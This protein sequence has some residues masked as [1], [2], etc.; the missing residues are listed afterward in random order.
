MSGEAVKQEALPARTSAPLTPARAVAGHVHPAGPEARAES[1]LALQRMAGNRATTQAIR[2]HLPSPAAVPDSAGA[3]LSDDLRED[4]ERRFDGD[5]TDVRVHSGATAAR[6]ASALSAKA[7]TVG[8]DIVFSEG[9]FAPQT[10]AGRHLLAHELAHVVQQSRGGPPPP[11]SGSS[12]GLEAA[13][14][15]SAARAVQSDGAIGVAGASSIGVARAPEDE[16]KNKSLTGRAFGFLS[17]NAPGL[18]KAAQSAVPIAETVEAS[19]SP[20]SKEQVARALDFIEKKESEGPPDLSKVTWVG[21]PPLEVRQKQAAAQRE[22]DQEAKK[23]N[24][25]G[26]GD[27]APRPG[28]AGAHDLPP[29]DWR[30]PL[31]DPTPFE[32]QLR[33]GNTF[34]HTLPP[35]KPDIDPR[36]ATWIGGRPSEATMRQTQFQ[37][38]GDLPSS[39]KIYVPGDARTETRISANDVM[40]VRDPDTGE[41]TGYRIKSGETIWEVDRNGNTLDTRGLEGALQEPA[42]DP[43]DVTLMF[44]Q[45][46][47]AIA[48]LVKAGGKALAQRVLPTASRFALRSAR[49]ARGGTTALMVGFARG[50]EGTGAIATGASWGG[51]RAASAEVSQAARG[52]VKESLEEAAAKGTARETAEA[53]AEGTSRAGTKKAASAIELNPTQAPDTPLKLET[54]GDW[55]AQRTPAGSAGV[56]AEAPPLVSSAEASAQ[57]GV[58]RSDALDISPSRVPFRPLARSDENNY[59]QYDPAVNKFAIHRAGTRFSPPHGGGTVPIGNA[60]W[61]FDAEGNPTEASTTQLSM[62]VRDP[63]M[64]ANVPGKQPGEDYSH[65]LGTDFGTIDA[66]LGRH[67]G[68]RQQAS[69]NRPIGGSSPWY[70]AERAAKASAEAL[71]QAGRPYRV[72]A[73]ARGYVNGVPAETRMFVESEGTVVQDSGWVRAR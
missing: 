47:P 61:T 49:F 57:P 1:V 5:F 53:A 32:N 65:L 48:S 73:Q 13:A 7:Y 55:M 20:K 67:G 70:N 18:A 71:E 28:A 14:N 44:I 42:V 16:E 58:P 9:R 41:L 66:L 43:I 38:A 60:N 26:L 68:F 33:S 51:T 8:R 59:V 50:A 27:P 52:I 45:A 72:V 31:P 22:R 10:S 46:A 63:V 54:T 24:P 21:T 25:V 36:T 15:R 34:A 30:A 11:I 2:S 12:G 69:L 40:P 35:A 4:M 6:S 3:P 64:Y 19:L 23:D 56:S 37:P 39:T 29:G 62:G 17:R